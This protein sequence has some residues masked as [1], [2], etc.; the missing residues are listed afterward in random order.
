MKGRFD[1]EGLA[2]DDVLLMPAKAEVP[3]YEVDVTTWLTKAIQL[4]IPV[5]SAAMDR[6][7]EARLAIAKIGRA[8][9]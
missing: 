1:K 5:V 6:V 3:K 8:H 9:V 2:F 4:N 7:T